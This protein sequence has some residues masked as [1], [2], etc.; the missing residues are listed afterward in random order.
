M[1]NLLFSSF[2]FVLFLN[3]LFLGGWILCTTENS[4]LNIKEK[5]FSIGDSYISF[6]FIIELLMFSIEAANSH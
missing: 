4:L 3:T 1:E 6:F 2:S 5:E